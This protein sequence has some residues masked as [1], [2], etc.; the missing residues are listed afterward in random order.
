MVRAKAPGRPEVRPRRRQD[1]ERGS[2]AILAE[3]VYEIDRAWIGPL[4]IFEEENKRL[5]PC[6]GYDPRDHRGQLLA[7]DLIGRKFRQ[8][9]EWNWNVDQRC[10]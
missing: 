4:Q 7:A 1:E 8:T 10:K 3:R 2:R 9:F 6:G 5:H